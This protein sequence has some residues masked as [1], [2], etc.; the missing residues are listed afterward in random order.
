MEYDTNDFEKDVI[1][2]SHTIPVLVDFWAAWCEPCTVLGPVLEKLA[3]ESDGRWELAK[4]DTERFPA[5]A[6]KYRIRSIPNVKLFVDG[7]VTEEFVGALP[8]SKV[9]EWLRKALPS[10]YDVQLE[11][12]KSLLR[13]N[14]L[15]EA[16]EIL[17]FIIAAESDNDQARLLLAQTYL[18]SD[19]KLAAK[20][21]DPIKLGSQSFEGAE[22]IGLLAALLERAESQDSFALDSVGDLYLAAIDKVRSNNLDSAL[23]G[24]IGV[25]RKN[26]EYDDDGSRKA[27]IAIFKLLGEADQVTRTHRPAFSAALY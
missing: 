6:T 24:F 27:C 12:A 19:P 18:G 25:I 11:G 9:A 13:R 5:V 23:D 8:E 14:S 17:E 16:R 7:Q 4:L 2:R 22:A 26:R 15:T 20:T 1:E 3:R 21:V 10:K